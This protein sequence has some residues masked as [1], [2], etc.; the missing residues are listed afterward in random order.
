M[1]V[2]KESYIITKN[3]LTLVTIKESLKGEDL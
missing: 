2:S 3:T 1:E